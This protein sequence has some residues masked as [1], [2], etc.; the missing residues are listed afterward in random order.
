MS[1]ENFDS[2]ELLALARRALENNDLEGGLLKLKKVIA[3][4]NP[5]DEALTMG[6]SVYAQLKLFDRA[7][8]LYQRYLEKNP[9]AFLE[10]FQLG[11]TRFDSG[12]PAEALKVW[13]EVL[14]EKPEFPPALF[15]KGLALARTEKFNEAKM[16]LDHVVKTVPADNLYFNRAKELLQAI[17]AGQSQA[18][19]KAAK[20]EAKAGI[21]APPDP[22][23]TE[24]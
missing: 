3:E 24:H 8:K 13:D 9:K 20:S 5:P 15:Y 23:R 17:D 7:E 1:L 22:Y 4:T 16:V 12:K 19:P 10:R 14:K 21:P 11:M 6:A 18:A 2:D